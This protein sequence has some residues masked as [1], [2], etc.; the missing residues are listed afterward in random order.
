MKTPKSAHIIFSEDF[1]SNATVA[2]NGGVLVNNPIVNRGMTTDST[3]YAT[4][5][6]KTGVITQG[7]WRW[8]GVLNIS[9]SD[10]Y[11]GLVTFK[12]DGS[13]DYGQTCGLVRTG[14]S[15][16]VKLNIGTG[17]AGQFHSIEVA[18]N[19]VDGTLYDIVGTWSGSSYNI[20]V[21][22]VNDNGTETGIVISSLKLSTYQD[23]RVGDFGTGSTN[24]DAT[25]Y[26]AEFR[27]IALTAEEVLDLYQQDTYSELNTPLIS[28]PFKSWYWKASGVELVT[29]GDFETDTTG[30]S[31]TN[32]TLSIISWY[33]GNGLRVTYGGAGTGLAY[34]LPLT[35]GKRYRFRALARG[36]GTS[37]PAFRDGSTVQWTGTSSTDWQNVDIEFVSGGT[38]VQLL[39]G[40][41][42]TEWDYVS[43]E[44]LTA[45]TENKGSGDDLTLGNGYTTSKFPTFSYPKKAYFNGTSTYVDTKY[46]AG[47]DYNEPVTAMF[48]IDL[49]Q[50]AALG[51][52][53]TEILISDLENS[54]LKGFRF[55]YSSIPGGM[56]LVL[57]KANSISNYMQCRTAVGAFAPSGK[58][59]LGATEDGT[60]TV[61]GTNF[62]LNG[63]LYPHASIVTNGD[64]LNN[65]SSV[66][67]NNMLIGAE[68]NSGALTDYGRYTLLD[69]Y[70]AKELS[71]P[72]QM[73]ELHNRMIKNV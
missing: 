15:S 31:A 56:F 44:E 70:F 39:C 66:S 61:A 72:T 24:L 16:K 19:L 57:T 40:T 42:Y 3:N 51:S 10:G 11:A 41:T 14:T 48:Y 29:N 50:W 28:A 17:A 23:L 9:S 43:V 54:P 67:G 5:Q 69:N 62:Y 25:T 52:H 55:F 2:E 6:K 45:T 32:S 26:I 27:D 63:E 30:W 33:S 46:T 47:V 37:A 12:G 49:E 64:T 22:G 60:G 34:Q 59:T 71:T 38:A 73:R 8:R 65:L 21:N 1:I 13:L 4:F 68:Y 7:T 20:Y 36:D 18:T 35:V 53:G 58:I